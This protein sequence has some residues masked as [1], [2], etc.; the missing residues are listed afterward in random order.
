M[1]HDSS[2]TVNIYLEHFYVHF[3][4]LLIINTFDP[5]LFYSSLLT[6]ISP[7]VHSSHLIGYCH[8]GA[9]TCDSQTS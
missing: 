8:S 7:G 1:S 3:Q 6:V 2:A 9:Q 5:R 4:N